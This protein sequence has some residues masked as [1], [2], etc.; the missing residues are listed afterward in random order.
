MLYSFFSVSEDNSFIGIQISIAML[1]SRRNLNYTIYK[2]SA[3]YFIMVDHVYDM[4]II[5]SKYIPL[6]HN[7][8]I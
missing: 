4:V 8:I 3:V 1:L 5:L 6:F 7:A 2:C